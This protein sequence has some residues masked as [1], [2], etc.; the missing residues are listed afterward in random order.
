VFGSKE[1]TPTEPRT[2]GKTRMKRLYAGAAALG[3]MFGATGANAATS[4]GTETFSVSVGTIVEF[5]TQKSNTAGGSITNWDVDDAAGGDEA[6]ASIVFRLV[7]NADTTLTG[8]FDNSGSGTSNNTAALVN[9]TTD[10]VLLTYANITTDGDSSTTPTLGADGHNATT[11]IAHS[12]FA[13]GVHNSLHGVGVSTAADRFAYI[14]GLATSASSANVPADTASEVF[15]ATATS[16]F[17]DSAG[18]GV[19]VT[20]VNHDGAVLVTVQVRGFN[21][22]DYGSSSDF[23]EAPDTGTYQTDLTLTATAP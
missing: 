9:T 15:G 14:G 22:E 10:E 21:G 13:S 3:L 6:T 2:H 7:M 4:S 11:D 19:V 18:G 16:D 1:P 17:L 20:H 23:T 12:G 5:I 8:S